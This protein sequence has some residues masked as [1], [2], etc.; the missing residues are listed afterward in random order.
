MLHDGRSTSFVAGSSV[1]AQRWV[2]TLRTYVGS[3]APAD[4]NA[5]SAPVDDAALAAAAAAGAP[6][7]AAAY[8][9]M[10]DED[11]ATAQ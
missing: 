5:P 7:S 9:R 8:V 2:E 4:T 6:A 1:Y 3:A 11:R 10:S